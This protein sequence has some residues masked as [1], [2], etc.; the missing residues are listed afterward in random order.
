MVLF[1]KGINYVFVSC[2]SWLHGVLR[3]GVVFSMMSILLV[4]G[5]SYDDGAYDM[6]PNTGEEW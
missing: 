5:V 4:G 6:G 1:P 3:G 2:A